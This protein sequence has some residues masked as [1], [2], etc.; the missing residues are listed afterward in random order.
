MKLIKIL[1][2]FI[3]FYFVVTV[4]DTMHS[5]GEW[6]SRG[7]EYILIGYYVLLVVLGLV[8]I[9]VPLLSYM[10]KPTIKKY[11]LALD[12]NEKQVNRIIKQL[13][14]DLANE[15][16]KAIPVDLEARKTY[17]KNYLESR[18][19]QFKKISK[20]Y[21]IKV[22][23]TVLFSP[24]SF[25]DGITILLSNSKMIHELSSMV[26]IRYTWKE[27]FKMYFSTLTVASVSGLIEEFDDAVIDAFEE[28]LEEIAERFG[29]ETGKAISDSIPL[30]N[31]AAK[32]L[33]FIIQSSV[34]YAFVIY[35]GRKFFYMINSIYE[36]LD[37][38]EI[39]KKSRKE[40]RWSRLDYAKELSSQVKKKAKPKSERKLFKKSQKDA[41]ID[42]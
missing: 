5:L 6:L 12:G 2:T 34:N 31:V 22:S 26:H 3:I 33:S 8:Y 1:S 14:K 37:E 16:K 18:A 13:S 28:L 25:I 9:L 20:S 15:D 23:S 19:S 24:N 10:R 36:E 4:I 38:K 29:E 41:T 39:L 17:I 42:G 32:S 7:N 11:K 35:N 21:A 27:L 30:V 40:A